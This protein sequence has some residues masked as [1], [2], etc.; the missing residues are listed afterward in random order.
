[1]SLRVNKCI[2]SLQV[3]KV[4]QMIYS[5]QMI[6]SNSGSLQNAQLVASEGSIHTTLW[7]HYLA[8]PLKLFPSKI[9]NE[10]PLYKVPPIYVQCHKLP[11]ISRLLNEFGR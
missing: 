8:P 7:R 6:N 11:K 2:S 1:M 5:L 4:S 3:Y 10:P 9:S